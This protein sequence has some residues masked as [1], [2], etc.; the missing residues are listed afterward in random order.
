[1]IIIFCDCVSNSPLNT[2]WEVTA[3]HFEKTLLAY[4]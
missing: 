1:M 2:V 3:E 4:P